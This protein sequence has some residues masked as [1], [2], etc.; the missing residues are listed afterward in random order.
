MHFLSLDTIVFGNH[1]LIDD[2]R[3]RDY[4]ADITYEF[5]V[6]RNWNIADDFFA[7]QGFTDEFPGFFPHVEN[8]HADVYAKVNIRRERNVKLR[9]V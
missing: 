4:Y 6:Y 2:G 1:S 9:I 7:V 3:Q 8:E 5:R